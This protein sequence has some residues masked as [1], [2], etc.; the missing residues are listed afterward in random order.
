MIDNTAGPPIEDDLFRVYVP[1]WTVAFTY[2]PQPGQS[3]AEAFEHVW[4]Y[5]DQRYA[6]RVRRED[7]QVVQDGTT[8]PLV[9]LLLLLPVLKGEFKHRPLA[10]AFVNADPRL[11]ERA[12]I[13]VRN[14][15]AD[16][17]LRNYSV[18]MLPPPAA[19]SSA[20]MDVTT[21]G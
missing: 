16:H 8:H 4:A 2:D 12:T 18:T 20:A 10:E 11:C 5:Y 1:E 17:D 19:P 14:S 15:K 9:R 13:V 3:T 7:V 6:G 21:D